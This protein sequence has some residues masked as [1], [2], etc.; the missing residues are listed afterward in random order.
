VADGMSERIPT[1][2]LVGAIAMILFWLF[3]TAYYG[4]AS[5]PWMTQGMGNALFYI[6]DIMWFIALVASVVIVIRIVR[7]RW[8]VDRKR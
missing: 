3:F 7:G 2:S 1:V 8:H 4:L 5:V 6:A